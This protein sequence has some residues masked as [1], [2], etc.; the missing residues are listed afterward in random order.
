MIA[1]V[2]TDPAE[3]AEYME[4]A[5]ATVANWDPAKHRAGSPGTDWLVV[6]RPDDVRGRVLTG[7]VYLGDVPIG[8]DVLAAVADA[9]EPD[10]LQSDDG[11]AA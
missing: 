7:A 2:C 1:I 5:A 11:T 4:L 3:A 6:V 9:L 8:A 10:A